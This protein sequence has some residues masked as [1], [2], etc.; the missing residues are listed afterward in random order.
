M[1][2]GSFSLDDLHH[3]QDAAGRLFLSE[4]PLLR[5]QSGL[6]DVPLVIVGSLMGHYSDLLRI[7]D[8][9]GGP[10]C[11]QRHYLFLGNYVGRGPLSLETITLLIALKVR[12][13]SCVWL[14]RGRHESLPMS[15]TCGFYDEVKRRLNIKE[16][17][18]HS[19]LFDV[20]PLALSLIHI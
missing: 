15:R 20:M 14:L 16:W 3:L 13:P 17:K 5:I 8:L 11:E 7:F 18:R 4:G 10:P 12:W 2:T 19:T 9:A 6:G 1:L